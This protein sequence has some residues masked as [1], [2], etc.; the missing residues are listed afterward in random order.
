MANVKRCYPNCR[1]FNCSKRAL[2]LRGRNAWCDWTSEAC[3]PK[4]CTYAMCRRR[5]L[6]D[7]GV[8]GRTIK[9]KT[10]EEKSP[11][12]FEEEEI[13][14]KGKLYRKTGERIIF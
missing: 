7:N 14:V 3:E 1:D 6:L 12:D 10:R 9:R 5:Q 13:R 4:S 11:E 8:C 2:R